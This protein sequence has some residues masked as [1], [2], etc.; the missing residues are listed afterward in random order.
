M[1]YPD[2]RDDL[3]ED[4]EL[5]QRL[6]GNCATLHRELFLLFHGLRAGGARLE[7]K[8]YRDKEK[9]VMLPYLKL[10]PGEVEQDFWEKE[11]KPNWL[12]PKKDDI[13]QMFWLTEMALVD[14]EFDVESNIPDE[15]K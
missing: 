7:K 1:L 8:E 11:V 2:P 12:M 5:W 3:H 4:S 13:K 9:D 15:W 6:L 14:D 10:L